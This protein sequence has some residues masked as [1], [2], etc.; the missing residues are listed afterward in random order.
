MTG[1]GAWLAAMMAPLAGRVL[2]ALGLSMVSVV[3]MSAAMAE[4]KALFLAKLLLA[5]AAGLQMALLGGLPE[6][7]GMIFGAMTFRLL[8]WQVGNARRILGA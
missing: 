3:G 7:V 4:L 5:P 2:A 6:G 8:L 1:L